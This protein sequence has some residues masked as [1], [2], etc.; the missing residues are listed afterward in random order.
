MD[1]AHSYSLPDKT[2]SLRNMSIAP[3]ALLG[4]S[5]IGALMLALG[6]FALNQMG[7]IRKAGEAIEQISVPSIT[8]L[9]QLT[10]LTLRLRTQ[11]GRASCRERVSSPV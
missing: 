8:N 10:Q 4:F 3:R 7:Q 2:M 11:I 6:I 1:R 9:D 5:L